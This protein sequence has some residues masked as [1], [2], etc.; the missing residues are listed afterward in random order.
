MTD[1]PEFSRPVRVDTLGAAPRAIG[2]EA[3]PAERAA[4][5]KRFG[6]L[7]LESLAG[8]VSLTRN[9]ERVTAR[10]RIRASVV[11]SCI[12]TGEPVQA[13]LDEPFEVEFRPLSHSDAEEEVELAGAE[14]DV[15]FYDGASADVGE[16]AAETLSL[17]LDPYPRSPAAEEALRA[18]GVKSEE[19]A[20]MASS[21]FA[22][23]KDKL[24]K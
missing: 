1:K 17:G 6:L 16:L 11:Q 12:A 24:G 14:L 8:E 5:A 22:V 13:A 4:L 9:G 15:V 21:P 18:A 20:R 7:G 3:D 23:L 10:G 2:I 19:E